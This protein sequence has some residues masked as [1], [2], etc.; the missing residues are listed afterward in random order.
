MKSLN[1]RGKK[2]DFWCE[3]RRGGSL[4]ELRKESSKLSFL[5]QPNR[6]SNGVTKRKSEMKAKSDV[7]SIL[8]VS[9]WRDRGFVSPMGHPYQSKSAL[10]KRPNDSCYLPFSTLLVSIGY[11]NQ[12]WSCFLKTVDYFFIKNCI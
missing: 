12:F 5:P 3:F 4:N 1:V 8:M 9:I 7:H 10:F 11:E 6:I 2:K